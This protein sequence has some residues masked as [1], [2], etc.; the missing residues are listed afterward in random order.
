MELEPFDSWGEEVD[1]SEEPT[2]PPPDPNKPY[3]WI[4]GDWVLVVTDSADDIP[5]ALSFPKG[6]HG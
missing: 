2:K 3:M 5:P 4:N 1:L 6:K